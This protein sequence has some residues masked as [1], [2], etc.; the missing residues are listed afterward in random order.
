[1]SVFAPGSPASRAAIFLP[2]TTRSRFVQ[3]PIEELNHKQAAAAMS[4]AFVD[5]LSQMENVL[6]LNAGDGPRGVVLMR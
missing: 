3:P 4:V 6:G 1:M 2:S 5:T